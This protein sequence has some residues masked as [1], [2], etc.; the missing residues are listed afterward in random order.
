MKTFRMLC[1]LLAGV[2]GVVRGADLSLPTN[3]EAFLALV[4][5][6]FGQ[7]DASILVALSFRELPGGNTVSLASVRQ[8]RQ[9]LIS[10][11]LQSLSLDPIELP[12]TDIIV[13][14]RRMTTNLPA[15]WM[16]KILHPTGATTTLFV[17]LHDGTL[18]TLHQEQA[19]E[20]PTSN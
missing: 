4:R 9:A 13:H 11:G 14:G 5:R 16:L 20:A 15:R 19:K 3:E 10:R 7:S 17:G 2:A 8:T 1:L 12:G 18:Y 6:A